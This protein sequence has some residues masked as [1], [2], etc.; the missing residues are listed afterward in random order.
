[1][2]HIYKKFNIYTTYYFKHKIF[3]EIQEIILYII[4]TQLLI[5]NTK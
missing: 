3:I 1:M 4:H 5:K 2:F